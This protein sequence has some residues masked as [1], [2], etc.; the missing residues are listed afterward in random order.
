MIGREG[1]MGRGG[2]RVEGAG[3]LPRGSRALACAALVVAGAAIPA[4]STSGPAEP[5]P[6]PP[7]PPPVEATRAFAMGFT[8]WPYEATASAQ[9]D[10][11]AKLLANGDFV[12]HHIDGGIPWP[13]A[14]AGTAPHANVEADLLEREIRTPAGTP[15]Y[16]S[17][18]PLSSPRDGLAEYWGASKAMPR[19]DEWAA[20]TFDDPE[21]V[22]AFVSWSLTLIDRFDPDWFNYGI[23]ITEL[24]VSG[25]EAE[26]DAL[27]TF[28]ARVHAALR[29]AHPDLPIFIS[30]GLKSPGSSDWLAVEALW[31]RLLPYSDYVGVSAYPYIFFDH[32]AKGDPDNLP[33]AWLTQASD[34]APAKPLAI[35]ETGWIAETLDIPQ[36]GVTV[37]ATPADQSAYVERLLE[38]LE[39]L[40][41]ELVIWFFP[42]DFD[43]LWSETL[44]GDPIARIWRDTGLWDEALTPRPAL[45]E[46]QDW[47][48]L[49]IR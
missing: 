16:L 9:T 21:V 2:G 45:A 14:Y 22:E 29:A 30:G 35:A 6:P 37:S 3:G 43:V 31:K 47:L 49:G 8:P 19:P 26:V 1:R 27:V 48:A 46:W 18:T 33:A 15:V 17:I 7:P 25:T 13:E 11:Y 12:A 41:A 44:A 10:V 24:A 23:E 34:L 28:A 38:E 42:I 36:Y 4:C 32:A 40:E 20:R 39:A 5:G